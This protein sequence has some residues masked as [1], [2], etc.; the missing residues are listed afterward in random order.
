MNDK[1]SLAQ[2]RLMWMYFTE[3]ANIANNTKYTP[4]RIHDAMCK[5][6]LYITD[7]LGNYYGEYD[8]TRFLTVRQ[9]YNFLNE[10]EVFA[11]ELDIRLP[12]PDDLYYEAMMKG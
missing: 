2:N 11:A 3:L 5:R 7:A 9:M 4:Q 10:V 8:T 12:H 6:H 1:R